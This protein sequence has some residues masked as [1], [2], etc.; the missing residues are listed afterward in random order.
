MPETN[1]EQPATTPGG[2]RRFRSKALGCVKCLLVLLLVAGFLRGAFA[3]RHW[4]LS[5]RPPMVGPAVDW[6]VIMEGAPDHWLFWGT[7]RNLRDVLVEGLCAEP[8]GTQSYLH[9]RVNTNEHGLRCPPIADKTGQYRILAVGDSTTFGHG[10]EDRETWP[11]QLQTML[12]NKGYAVD[13]I[14]AGG[15]GYSAFQGMRFLKDPGLSFKP[16][17]VIITF[18]HNEMAVWGGISDIERGEGKLALIKERRALGD[19]EVKRHPRLNRQEYADI[20]SAMNYLCTAAGSAVIFLAWPYACDYNPVMPDGSP[21]I[22]SPFTY[23]SE[24]FEA[25]KRTGSPVIDIVAATKGE[26]GILMDSVH[27]HP[28]GCQIVARTIAA[29]LEEEGYLSLPGEGSSQ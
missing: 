22:T 1:H 12:R 10:V 8:G 11:S 13:V 2:A 20:L 14:N 19:E 21:A 23:Y 25:G 7:E 4:R 26:D 24:T 15:C 5:N 6:S 9:F 28:K 29:F 17:L 3:I 18:G 16:D 27:F